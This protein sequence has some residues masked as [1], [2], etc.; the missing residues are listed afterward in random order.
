M[1]EKFFVQQKTIPI[2]VKFLLGK[3]VSLLIRPDRKEPNFEINTYIPSVSRRFCSMAFRE[4]FDRE[5]SSKGA[6]VMQNK[7]RKLETVNQESEIK[8]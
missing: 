4:G 8:P 2:N 5:K 7:S 3:K 6:N 1:C